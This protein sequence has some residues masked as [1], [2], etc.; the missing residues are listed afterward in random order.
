M[1]DFG[2]RVPESDTENRKL[3][4]A[5]GCWVVKVKKVEGRKADYKI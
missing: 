4:M 3:G 5:L 2:T 1:S